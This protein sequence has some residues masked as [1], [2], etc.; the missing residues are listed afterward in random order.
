[1]KKN[2]TNIYEV[3]I[4]CENCGRQYVEGYYTEEEAIEKYSKRFLDNH[5]VAVKHNRKA[6][7]RKYLLNDSIPY[8]CYFVCY[9][10]R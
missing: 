1:M 7:T 9:R 5:K 2:W 3:I 8:C 6:R 10:S 4:K